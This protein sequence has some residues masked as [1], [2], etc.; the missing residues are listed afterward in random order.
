MTGNHPRNRRIKSQGQIADGTDLL[1]L[2][3]V[4]S[5]KN[6]ALLN[7]KNAAYI[8]YVTNGDLVSNYGRIIRLYAG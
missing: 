7:L 1:V 3:L 2:L 6:A 5:G 4:V 8:V